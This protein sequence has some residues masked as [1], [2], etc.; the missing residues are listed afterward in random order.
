MMLYIWARKNPDMVV[1]FFDVFHF[2]SCFLP[3]F[4][5]LLIVLSGYDPT[6]DIIGSC[7]GH[8]YFYLEDVVPHLPETQDIRLVRAPGFL[9]R[10][11]DVL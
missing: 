7:V 8:L 10:L 11:C 5:L 2:R 3:H 9:K 6:M 1:S 4:M